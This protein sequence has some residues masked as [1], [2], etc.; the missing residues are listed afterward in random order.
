MDKQEFLKL[1]GREATDYAWNKYR[2]RE[3]DLDTMKKALKAW[4]QHRSVDWFKEVN[5][6]FGGDNGGQRT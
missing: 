2:T 6:T 3:W 5:K 1:S 4:E